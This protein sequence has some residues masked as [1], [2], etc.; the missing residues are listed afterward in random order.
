MPEEPLTVTLRAAHAGDREAADRAYATLYPELLKIARARLR[1]H[2]P[3]TLLDTEGL[4]HESFLRFV[5]ADKLGITDRKHFFTYA[6]KTMRNIV[7]DFARRRQAERRGGAAERVTLDTHLLGE[8]L[9]VTVQPR[10]EREALDGPAARGRS[11]GVAIVEHLA[12]GLGERFRGRRLVALPAVRVRDADAGLVTHELDRSA[13]RRIRDRQAAGHRF[14]H[15]ARAWI[16]HLRVQ[17]H[18]RAANH[19]WR[20]ALRVPAEEFRQCLFVL[21]VLAEEGAVLKVQ[22]PAAD[23][24]KQRRQRYPE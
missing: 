12:H 10:D 19:G 24:E 5:A 11:V 16:V 17:Q 20:L 3:N 14:D 1:V 9:R 8:D 15:R 21:E 18:V 7:I 4:V 23:K 2:Q 22:N 13:A 6:A